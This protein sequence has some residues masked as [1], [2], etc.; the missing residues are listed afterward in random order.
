[1][2]SFTNALHDRLEAA[3]AA[4]A[5]RRGANATLMEDRSRRQAAFDPAAEV[6]YRTIIRPMVE[7]VARAFDNATV[8]HFKMP[9]GFTSRCLLA[10]TDRYPA[11]TELAIGIGPAGDGTGAV[12]TYRLQIIPELMSY[13][14]SDSWTLDLEHVALDEVRTRL[15]DWLLRFTDTY[16]RLECEPNYQDWD[17]HLDPVCGMRISGAAAAHVIE[18]ERRKIYFCSED[19][20]QR[21][22][23][24]PGLYLTGIAPL[25]G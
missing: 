6:V 15:S 22:E 14:R 18:H 2:S 17:T 12:L 8:E 20:R 13:S 9:T 19:C 5:G 23:A 3:A 21:F 4:R 1:M 16:L 11:S 7:E 24:N 25:S 10:R